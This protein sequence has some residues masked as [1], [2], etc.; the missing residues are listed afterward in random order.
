ML[1]TYCALDM[2][3]R[4]NIY[5]CIAPRS[6]LCDYQW[7]ALYLLCKSGNISAFAF[8]EKSSTKS[9]CINPLENKSITLKSTYL[10]FIRKLF[11][12][13]TFL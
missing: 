4:E 10:N 1:K 6:S 13:L 11:S 12:Q 7:N 8:E 5:A 9:I 3:T 2:L